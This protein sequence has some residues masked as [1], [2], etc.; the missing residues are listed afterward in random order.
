MENAQFRPQELHAT[1]L[2]SCSIDG[3]KAKLTQF[4]CVCESIERCELLYHPQGALNRDGNWFSDVALYQAKLRHGA[5]EQFV[6]L[7]NDRTPEDAAFRG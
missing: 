1:P 4:M 2:V 7:S 5:L 3:A 6:D